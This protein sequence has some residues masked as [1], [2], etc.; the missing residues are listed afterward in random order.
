MV[1][2]YI[3]YIRSILETSAVVWHSSLTQSEIKA[4]ERVQK[5]ALRI[6][7]RQNYENYEQ[8]LQLVELPTLYA[9]RTVLCINFAEQ[10][11][12][13]PKTSDMFP[14]NQSTSTRNHEKFCVQF[15]NNQRPA[16][17]AIPYM[18]RL[19]NQV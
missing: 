15:S 13:N 12:T 1:D 16:N 17:S 5:V 7:L 2:I 14:R 9:R 10:C 8:A 19:L 4:I 3:L 18:Q 11:R 6:I